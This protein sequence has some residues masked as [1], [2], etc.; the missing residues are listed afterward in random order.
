MFFYRRFPEL[1]CEGLY[2]TRSGVEFRSRAFADSNRRSNCPSN[3][4]ASVPLVLAFQL[5]STGE[6]ARAYTE[7][8]RDYS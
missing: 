6:D 3:V 2:A 1:L 5:P 7:T 8:C 4:G